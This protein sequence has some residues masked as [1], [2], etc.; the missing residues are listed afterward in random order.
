VPLQPSSYPGNKYKMVHSDEEWKN[1][2]SYIENLIKVKQENLNKLLGN[3]DKQEKPAV[4]PPSF[5]GGDGPAE[6]P[7]TWYD[8]YLE[9]EK[10][11]KNLDSS[12]KDF[13]GDLD[14]TPARVDKSL[15]AF[16][17][18]LDSES[19][20]LYDSLNKKAEAR[21]ELEKDLTHKINA[22]KYSETTNA[23]LLLDEETEYIE[24][25]YAGQKEI[26]DKANE[27]KRL[28][29]DE[30]SNDTKKTFGEEMNDAFKGWASEWS[31]T[32]NEV[33]WDSEATFGD[34]A[35]S[36]G[37]MITQM[38]LQKSIIE[39]LADGSS[40]FFTTLMSNMFGTYGGAA[41]A[42]SAG[43]GGAAGLAGAR[44]FG[45][46][47]SGGKSYL[48]GERGPEIFSPSSSGTIIPNHRMGGGGG[49]DNLNLYITIN[50]LDSKSVNQAL[51]QH[52]G[53]IVGMVQK[54]YQKRG[55]GGGPLS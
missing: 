19:S 21:L 18:D 51:G 40:R 13:F 39:P 14:E 55:K 46:P 20:K 42:G 7:A 30:I 52:A 8:T 22:L 35:T 54:A 2:L 49:G 38:M 15:S 45:G 44:E 31:S 27:Y 43:S 50:A 25:T 33:L 23:I 17:G 26:I 11:I 34:I 36:F 41:T 6:K 1:E 37:K 47:V 12:L 10:K 53:Q 16:F 9:D 5:V 28:A 32:L 48:V 4:K 29:L 3:R 24:K